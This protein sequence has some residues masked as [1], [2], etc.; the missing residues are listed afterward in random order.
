MGLAGVSQAVLL[1]LLYAPSQM[2]TG[3]TFVLTALQGT[4]GPPCP[5]SPAPPCWPA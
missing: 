1:P 4:L 2:G 5:P 3:A